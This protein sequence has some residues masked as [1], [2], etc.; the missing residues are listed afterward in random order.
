MLGSGGLPGPSEA[1]ARGAHVLGWGGGGRGCGRPCY[2]WQEVAPF[3][4]DGETEAQGG[5]FFCLFV[6]LFV[7]WDL[8]QVTHSES[9]FGEGIA[10]TP[11]NKVT[12]ASVP[13]LGRQGR[14]EGP[15][16]PGG[17]H[18]AALRGWGA[19]RSGEGLCLALGRAKSSAGERGGGILVRT[20][21][22][23][24]TGIHFKI[25][26]QK[27]SGAVL[28]PGGTPGPYRSPLGALQPPRKDA[29]DPGGLLG[30][31]PFVTKQGQQGRCSCSSLNT[32]GCRPCSQL[33]EGTPSHPGQRHLGTTV[34]GGG[35]NQG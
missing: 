21:F 28:K 15:R 25:S 7:F 5:F 33:A 24:K 13:T 32:E 8:A 23:G 26:A 11:G 19:G 22:S 31:I 3:F 10:H 17:G 9:A 2:C 12:Q 27:G 35:G 16:R 14:A 20:G 4:P 1:E 30:E 6:C 29:G 18:S 34:R